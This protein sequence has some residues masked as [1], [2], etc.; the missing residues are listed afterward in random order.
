MSK[1]QSKQFTVLTLCGLLSLPMCSAVGDGLVTSTGTANSEIYGQ[2]CSWETHA[3]SLSNL[4]PEGN[5]A[6]RTVL[7]DYL[8]GACMNSA[9]NLTEESGLEC[10]RY[11]G[12]IAFEHEVRVRVLKNGQQVGQEAIFRHSHGV[13]DWSQHEGRRDLNVSTTKLSGDILQ[14]EGRIFSPH[15]PPDVMDSR[16]ADL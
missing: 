2:F 7:H 9:C 15:S 6:F 3:S 1:H 8:E 12:T 10:Q 14:L 16:I 13:D 11:Q 5:I 4:D